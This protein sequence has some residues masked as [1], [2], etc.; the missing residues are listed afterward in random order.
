[1]IRAALLRWF[2]AHR[3]PLPWRTACDPYRIWI[4]EIMLQQ[5]RVGAVLE[6]YAE[7]LRRFPDLNSLA[8]AGA[9]DV[10]AAWSGLGYYRRA[11]AL[12]RAARIIV[13]DHGGNLPGNADA[14]QSLPGIG[15]YTASA[16]ASIAFHEPCAVVDG[17]VERVLRRLFGWRK[18]P[19]SRIW[20]AAQQLLS[21]RSPG[22][23]NQAMMELGALVCLPV[24][25]RCEACPVRRLCAT[26]GPLQR[27]ARPPR[28]TA[29]IAYGLAARDDRVYLV[30]RG[31][32]ESLMPGMWE[33]P[34]LFHGA[35]GAG[36]GAAHRP[37]LGRC[38][39][40][41]PDFTLR[42]SITVTD[43]TFHVCRVP[44]A[45]LR[46]GRWFPLQDAAALPL[47]GLARRIL[48]RAALF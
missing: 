46:G 34:Q 5:T 26:C 48:R 4:S 43:H 16:I 36:D 28:K 30:R 18:Q 9:H 38:G 45:G 10:L 6:H 14:L 35:N 32:R 22:N 44:A 7:F 39:S 21:R 23:F 33:L 12:H 25:P 41:I 11:R 13:H 8:A 37:G 2:A 27:P 42:H 15:R 47:T 29:E 17:N 3:R 20:N 40:L 1:M 31:R 19:L 24:S